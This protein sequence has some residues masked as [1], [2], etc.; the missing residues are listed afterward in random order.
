[1]LP[2]N[3]SILVNNSM[4]NLILFLELVTFWSSNVNFLITVI[5]TVTHFIWLNNWL[6]LVT[7]KTYSTR[8][9]FVYDIIFWNALSLLHSMKTIKINKNNLQ[10]IFLLL[11]ACLHYS[12]NLCHV[13]I[14]FFINI[15]VFSS[16]IWWVFTLSIFII[17]FLRWLI[18][19]I[20][21]LSIVVT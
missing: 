1:M 12:F 11:G 4:D 8:P 21:V 18:L 19:W 9:S 14:T 17:L 15:F 3:H 7:T 5:C 6:I 10:R 16:S 20:T 2:K 13:Q